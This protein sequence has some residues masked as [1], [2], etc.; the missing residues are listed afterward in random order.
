MTLARDLA[1]EGLEG[2][3]VTR[4]QLG[5]LGMVVLWLRL[6]VAAKVSCVF[7]RFSFS[8]CIV[9]AKFVCLF[10]FVFLQ[11]SLLMY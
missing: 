3:G 11:T 9:D 2:L 8:F 6:K 4:M 10:C 7:L 5:F 1:L